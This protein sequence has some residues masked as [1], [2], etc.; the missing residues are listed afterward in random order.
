MTERL[1]KD[2]W[3]RDISWKKNV[4][5]RKKITLLITLNSDEAIVEVVHEIIQE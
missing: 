5:E 3:K 4:V 2:A 1:E